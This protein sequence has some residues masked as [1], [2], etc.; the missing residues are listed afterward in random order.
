MK[1]IKEWQSC[2]EEEKRQAKKR[3][4]DDSSTQPTLAA[5]INQRTEYPSKYLHKHYNKLMIQ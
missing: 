1:H 4:N 3:K 2:E 5:V